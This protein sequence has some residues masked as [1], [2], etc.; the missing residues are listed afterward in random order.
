MAKH[1]NS[2]FDNRSFVPSD[3]GMKSGYK[4]HEIS[5]QKSQSEF[6]RNASKTHWR[7]MP[8][9]LPMRGGIRL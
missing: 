5:P 9:R 1:R 6:T 2:G 7:N 8:N 4:R 3:P